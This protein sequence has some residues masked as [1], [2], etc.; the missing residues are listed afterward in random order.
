MIDNFLDLINNG[1]AMKNFYEMEK[2][3]AD[4]LGNFLRG[5][6]YGKVEIN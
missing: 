2:E 4:A 6:A 1:L 5:R 3:N